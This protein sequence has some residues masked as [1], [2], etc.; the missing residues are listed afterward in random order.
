MFTFVPFWEFLPELSGYPDPPVSE[1]SGVDCKL[2]LLAYLVL[3]NES[4]D[5]G[6]IYKN[7]MIRHLKEKGL[8]TVK[9]A[10]YDW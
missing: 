7:V 2:T 9:K 5:V 1:Q 10:S 8:K 4:H 6:G 3:Y